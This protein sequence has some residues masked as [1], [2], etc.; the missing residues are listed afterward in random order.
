[1]LK[2]LLL[3]SLIFIFISPLYAALPYGVVSASPLRIVTSP[4]KILN[5][6]VSSQTNTIKLT[7]STTQ[8]AYVNISA[9]IGK[10]SGLS[11]FTQTTMTEAGSPDKFGII[12]TPQK[13]IVPPGQ[14]RELNILTILSKK[15]LEALKSDLVYYITIKSVQNFKNDSE[16]PDSKSKITETG[17]SMIP[18]Y[19]VQ[20]IIRPQKEKGINFNTLTFKYNDST[21]KINIHNSGTSF[22]YIEY[23][24]QCPQQLN[25]DKLILFKKQHP[26]DLASNKMCQNLGGKT[27]FSKN[28]WEVSTPTRDHNL[29]FFLT[30]EK[31]PIVCSNKTKSCT[32]Y[33]TSD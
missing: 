31:K 7:N 1:M 3:T 5:A 4:S 25:L 24:F 23:V 27:L 18:E 15:R 26:F 12:I 22:K 8:V 2:K 21:N 29:V 30:N 14:S 6:D 13:L 20:Y 16:T 32:R 11:D 19:I 17:L 28:S 9:T 33:T 10:N